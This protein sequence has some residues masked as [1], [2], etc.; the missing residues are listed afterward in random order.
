MVGS[1]AFQVLAVLFPS[2]F[3]DFGVVQQ[4]VGVLSQD[5]A[6]VNLCFVADGHAG[7]GG[8]APVVRG[9]AGQAANGQKTG[10]WG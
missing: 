4:V 9:A 8:C 7:A 5:F 3:D 1:S 6:A 10:R 2:F